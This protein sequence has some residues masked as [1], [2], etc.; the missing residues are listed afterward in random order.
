MKK[1]WILAGVAVGLVALAVVWVL[2]THTVP[3]RIN[4]DHVERIG[5]PG[6]PHSREDIEREALNCRSAERAY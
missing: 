6:G 2:L 3:H 1:K 5:A 4:A